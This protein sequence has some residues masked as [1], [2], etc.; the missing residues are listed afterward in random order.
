MEVKF[1]KTKDGKI[2][3]LEFLNSQDGK[4]QN[5]L[6]REIGFLK[7]LGTALR[8]PHSEHLQ[9]GIFQLR[10]QLGNNISRVLYF[11]YVGDKA[12]LTNGFLKK[13]Q[14]TPPRELEIAKKYR[15]DYIERM[16][17]NEVAHL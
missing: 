16:S 11:F 5:K 12:I 3:A 14:A 9:D 17:K 15:D 2:P 7:E 1:Y 10:A 4:M 8:M 6:E 13:T